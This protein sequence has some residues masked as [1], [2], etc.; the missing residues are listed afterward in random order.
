MNR[1]C[2]GYKLEGLY[3]R[4]LKRVVPLIT[5]ASLFENYEI[6]M[7][8]P[9][10]NKFERGYLRDKIRR[11]DDATGTSRR[12][13]CRHRTRHLLCQFAIANRK[14]TLGNVIVAEGDE[15]VPGT[16]VSGRGDKGK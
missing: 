4:E 10:L 2:K 14:E 11:N 7:K 15:R 5:N 1:Q 13:R 16:S 9:K 6:R 3:C 8:V 12:R